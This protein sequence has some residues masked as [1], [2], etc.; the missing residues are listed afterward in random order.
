MYKTKLGLVLMDKIAKVAPRLLRFLGVLSIVTGFVGMV[1]IFYWLIK[2][3]YELLFVP[4][5]LPA[6]APVLPG[7][8]VVSGLPVLSF[9]HWII[10]IFLVAVVHEFSHGIYARL[11]NVKIK[12]SGF[13]FLG[14]ILAAFVEPEEKQLS[15]APRRV[16]LS[17][18]SAGPFSNMVFAIVTLLLLNF[19]TGPTYAQLYRGDGI[20]VGKLLDGYPAQQAGIEAPF[21]ITGLNGN[22]TRD[23]GQFLGATQHF[24]PGQEVVLNTDKGDY[25]L[26]LAENPDNK[27]K[28]FLGVANFNVKTVFKEEI[29]KQ[30][31]HFWP[32]AFAWIHML[33]FWLFIINLGVGLFN[34]LPLGPIDGGRMFYTA[35][36]WFSTDQHKVKKIWSLISLFCF[37]LIFINLAPYLWKLLLFMLKPFVILLGV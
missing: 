26:V 7:I 4:N 25:A 17:V 37:L 29:I 16:Q 35:L 20:E 13:A 5:A 15:K 6:V 34:L 23:L 32:S 33:V 27:S 14:P 9:W 2:G 24:E 22:T 1:F 36:T 30:Y 12:S 8:K 21:I 11:Y 3:T 28:A 18:F 19:A 31:G 10:A